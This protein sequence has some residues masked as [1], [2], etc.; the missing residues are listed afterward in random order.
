MHQNREPELFV[1]QLQPDPVS[2]DEG[3]QGRPGK[4]SW[5]N[6]CQ[7]NQFERLERME[8]E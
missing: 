3:P 4:S 6:G 7:R 8:E 5:K 2:D 1:K